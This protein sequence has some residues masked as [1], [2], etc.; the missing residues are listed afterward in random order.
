MTRTATYHVTPQD[1]AKILSGADG[2]DLHR[3]I[4]GGAQVAMKV[5]DVTPGSIAARL[6]AVNGDTVETINDQPLTS[7]AGAY[8]A[9][10][11]AV[12]TRRIVLRGKRGSEPYETTLI[13]DAN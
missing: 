9:G 8:Q 13:I 2:V 4:E 1:I 11:A 3:I 6:G 10:D 7:I 5:V 12:K